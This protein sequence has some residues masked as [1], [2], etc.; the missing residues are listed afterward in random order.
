LQFERVFN[1]VDAHTAGEAVRVILTGF[2]R[3][4]CKSIPELQ[5]TLQKSYDHLRRQII[6]EPRGHNDM[7]GVLV[8]EPCDPR[9]DLGAIFM[10]YAGIVN[11]NMCGH[12]TIGLATV[13]VEIGLVEKKEP[14]TLITF[15][16]PAGLVRAQVSC[17]RGI[18]SSV[19]LEMVPSV[20]LKMDVP[21]KT[22][23]FGEIEVSICFGGQL[24]SIV[25]AQQL[26]LELSLANATKIVQTGQEI[27]KAISEQISVAH[28]VYD[29]IN[30][31]AEVDFIAPTPS[32]GVDN[33]N[34]NVSVGGQLDRSPCGTGTCSTMA[35]F[36]AKGKLGLEQ[37][38]VNESLLGTKF[39]G[40]LIGKTK[41]GELDGVIP[42]VSGSSYIT[43][44]NSFV[45]SADDPLKNG[46]QMPPTN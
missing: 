15:D 26:G 32:Q 13:A 31:V 19:T 6:L 39:T 23:H 43:G 4:R 12:A 3:L 34:A 17:E 9:G 37:D 38:F 28:P 35:L 27:R 44:F 18:V 36:Y 7:F 2:P 20:V 24:H 14:S 11:N 10:D 29:R 16:T 21:I 40:R 41:V 5:M 45:V 30:F 8:T 33:L 42:A 25:E 22:E 46:F 1:V